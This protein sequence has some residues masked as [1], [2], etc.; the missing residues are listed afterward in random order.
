[1]QTI[2]TFGR[3]FNWSTNYMKVDFLNNFKEIEIETP[4]DKIIRQIRDLISSGQLKAGDRLPSERMMSEKFGVGRTSVRDAIRKLEFYGILRTL[5]QSGT[6]VSGLGLTA[7]EG[8]ITDVL[9]L[10]QHDFKA[11]IETRVLLE[12]NSAFNA[13]QR[14]SEKDLEGMR[15]ALAAYERVVLDGRSSVEEDLMFHLKIMEAA[16]NSVLMS[17]MMIVTPDILTYFTENRICSGDRPLS[18]LR[19]HHTILKH[20]EDQNPEMAEEAM[21]YH[22]QELLNFSSNQKPKAN[23]EKD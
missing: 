13:A 22:L 12:R 14:R 8:L 20:I 6:E 4:A 19:E 23:E 7:L 11:L 5:P 10:E 2:S 21:R 1:M 15:K 18:A 16:K 17:L 3:P 9:K